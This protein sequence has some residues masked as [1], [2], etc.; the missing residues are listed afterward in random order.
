MFLFVALLISIETRGPVF[1][2]QARVGLRLSVFEVFK[3]RS[4]THE[5]RKLGNTPIIGR[6]EGVTRMGFYLRR[7]KIDEWPQFWSVLRGEMSLIGPRPGVPEQLKEMSDRQKERYAVRPGLTGLAQVSGNIHLSWPERFEWDLIYIERM[8][9]LLDLKIL[10]R[11]FLLLF[12]GEAY[13][14]NKPLL[15]P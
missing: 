9:L 13:F 5:H 8:S 1:F 14:R 10:M 12:Y 11:T 15:S 7:F 3:F 2:R 6:A 4:M